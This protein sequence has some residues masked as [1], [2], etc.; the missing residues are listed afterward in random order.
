MVISF[1][2]FV[3]LYKSYMIL[4]LLR[5]FF[6]LDRLFDFLSVYV[7]G[8]F[9][10]SYLVSIYRVLLLFLRIFFNVYMIL[11]VMSIFLSILDIFGVVI[12]DCWGVFFCGSW[13]F[14]NFFF[15]IFG[16]FVFK[17]F[18]FFFVFFFS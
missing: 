2:V 18:D 13:L 16:V 8:F 3:I 17:I 12:E 1:I 15:C 10:V 5:F 6:S 14:V 7:I 4:V 9:V 11:E